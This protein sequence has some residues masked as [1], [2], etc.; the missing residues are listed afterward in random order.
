M[1]AKQFLTVLF[2]GLVR[3]VGLNLIVQSS[4]IPRKIAIYK[5]NLFD[6]CKLF[7]NQLSAYTVRYGLKQDAFSP[8]KRSSFAS[9]STADEADTKAAYHWLLWSIGHILND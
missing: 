4:I 7:F 3:L 6:N 9:G 2:M 8:K 5:T 1:S